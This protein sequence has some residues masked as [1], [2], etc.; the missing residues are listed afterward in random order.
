MSLYLGTKLCI[1]G[2]LK[3]SSQPFII[4]ADKVNTSGLIMAVA[5][6]PHLKYFQPQLHEA[7]IRH[8]QIVR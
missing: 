3:Q 6:T 1:L 7:L 8:R 5:G 4:S 2:T